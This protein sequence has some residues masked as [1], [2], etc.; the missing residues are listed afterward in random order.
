MNSRGLLAAVT[1]RPTPGFALERRS[2][3]L[4][5]LDVLAAGSTG[6]AREQCER[7][8]RSQPYNFCNLFCAG[9]DGAYV[10]RYTGAPEINALE[11]G[12]H[13]LGNGDLNDFTIPK[14]A[15]VRELL[16]DAPADSLDALAPV[17]KSVCADHE[18]ATPGE[19]AICMHGERTVTLSSSII[20]LSDAGI[21]SSLYLHAAGRPCSAP[22]RDCSQVFRD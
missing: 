6:D 1:D 7:G 20:A 2:R 12:V 18:A 3:G 19:R 16:A 11:P 10:V 21:E 13:L 5:C 9:P 14:L 15:R 8:L 4:F 22:Y 17:L